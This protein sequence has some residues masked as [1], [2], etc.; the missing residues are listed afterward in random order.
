MAKIYGL[1]SLKVKFCQNRRSKLGPRTYIY[2]YIYNSRRRRRSDEAVSLKSGSDLQR[3]AFICNEYTM[4][5]AWYLF[6]IGWY[7]AIARVGI[8]A[9]L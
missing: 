5:L 9:I 1:K 6:L 4:A 7:K 8:I 3:Y 2:I